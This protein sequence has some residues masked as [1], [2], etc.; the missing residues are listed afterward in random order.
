MLEKVKKVDSE[1][2]DILK[3][4][5]ELQL[6][7]KDSVTDKLDSFNEDDFNSEPKN[8]IQKYKK[9][10]KQRLKKQLKIHQIRMI[11]QNKKN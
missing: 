1:R 4:I 9:K 5:R 8:L 11:H 6:E 3:D 7:F 10:L 2:E